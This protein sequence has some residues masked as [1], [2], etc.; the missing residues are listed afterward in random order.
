MIA[1]LAA[2]VYAVPTASHIY[3]RRLLGSS[4]GV[5]GINATYD[6]II[7]GGGTGGLALA[8]RLA[9]QQAGSVAV[10]EA[11]GFYELGNGNFSQVPATDGYWVGKEKND[12][13]PLVDWG[14]VTTPQA[15]SLE[16]E[17]LGACN[18]NISQGCSRSRDS[19]C[20][21]KVSW[22]KFSKEL[23]ELPERDHRIVPD[24]GRS[25]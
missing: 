9:E 13:N 7:V 20:A 23:H 24:M 14:Y 22:W 11:G 8:T 10:V 3:A 12:T 15:V 4:F 18:I 21:W 6:Y 1:S 5:P 25:R 2:Y 19:L 16:M 17:Q